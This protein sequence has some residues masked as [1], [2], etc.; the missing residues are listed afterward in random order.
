MEYILGKKDEETKKSIKLLISA[1]LGDEIVTNF[2]SKIGED[3][4]YISVGSPNDYH[5]FTDKDKESVKFI[6]EK[7]DSKHSFLYK[8]SDFPIKQLSALN[9]IYETL[10][11]KFYGLYFYHRSHMNNQYILF[12]KEFLKLF[13]RKYK[14]SNYSNEMNKILT[15]FNSLG[16]SDYKIQNDKKD[17][18]LW[19]NMDGDNYL[20]D[21]EKMAESVKNSMEKSDD[22]IV[23]EI[24][25]DYDKQNI[26]NID[27]GFPPISEYDDSKDHYDLNR[28]KYRLLLAFGNVCHKENLY[29]FSHKGLNLFLKDDGFEYYTIRLKRRILKEYE[30]LDDEME[31]FKT[32]EFGFPSTATIFAAELNR[33]K[34]P[35]VIF[36]S[37]GMISV[38]YTNNTRVE[39]K[40]PEEDPEIL[41]EKYNSIFINGKKIKLGDTI[42]NH[43]VGKEYYDMKYDLENIDIKNIFGM[44]D[45]EGGLFPGKKP[46]VSRIGLNLPDT[47]IKTNKKKIYIDGV[48]FDTDIDF[49]QSGSK[50]LLSMLWKRG[51]FLS[52]LGLMYYQETGKIMRHSITLPD[53]FN[54]QNSSS[55]RLFKYIKTEILELS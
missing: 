33:Q 1:I 16:V 23:Y 42:H 12:A 39:Y 28:H 13:S 43:D 50:E 40:N 2:Y 19:L 15:N 45:S 32:R 38:C 30:V 34:I 47:D 36:T 10:I 8:G 22:G 49:G 55:K 31:N 7:M 44:G 25:G 51:Y 53:W 27:R 46:S 29:M 21:Y 37:E 35:N 14:S 5:T 11:K 9:P 6:L 48:L 20:K 54:T 24:E 17:G 41:F 52:F 4:D 3:S 26:K 18:I